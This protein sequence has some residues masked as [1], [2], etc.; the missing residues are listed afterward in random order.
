MNIAWQ[1]GKKIG[2]LTA[3]WLCL[4]FQEWTYLEGVVERDVLVIELLKMR[5]QFN[6]YVFDGAVFLIFSTRG[7]CSL[8]VEPRRR[9]P[10]MFVLTHRNS[11]TPV[12]HWF[13]GENR[14]VI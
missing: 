3:R 12:A 14:L 11:S 8:S 2:P 5:M 7:S 9:V 4:R 10:C 1:L 13:Y 6:F